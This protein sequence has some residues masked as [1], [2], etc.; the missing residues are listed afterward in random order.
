MPNFEHFPSPNKLYTFKKFN[1]YI[2]VQKA[3]TWW[4]SR[5]ADGTDK[6]SYFEISQ[7]QHNGQI[8]TAL[9]FFKYNIRII[10]LN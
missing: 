10:K 5:L 6:I 9:V 8:A 4:T 2:T 3:K 7:I 1:R